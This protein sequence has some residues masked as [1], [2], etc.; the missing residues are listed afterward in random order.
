MNFRASKKAI[1][2]TL[3]AILFATNLFFSEKLSASEVAKPSPK[4]LIKNTKQLPAC[5]NDP[6]IIDQIKTSQS[7]NKKNKF[8]YQEYQKTFT[9]YGVDDIELF[10]RLAYA[11]TLAANCPEKNRE[12]AQ[13]V[14]DVIFNRVQKRKSPSSVI[15]ERDQFASSLNFYEESQY[16]EFLC[17][18]DQELWELVHS[19]AKNLF[20]SK[21]RT[22][23]SP[24]A[25]NYYFFLHSTKFKPPTWTETLTPETTVDRLGKICVRSYKNP[26]WK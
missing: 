1:Q 25:T 14:T 21:E 20:S 2:L 10:T 6:A 3:T 9:K 18:Q 15:Y 23:I 24:E 26:N 13:V 17:P 22:R 8:K 16:A 5:I 7:N 19:R 12:V 11:E 4:D